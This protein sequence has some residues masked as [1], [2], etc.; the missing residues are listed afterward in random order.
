MTKLIALLL[1]L[2]VFSCQVDIP[3]EEVPVEP[4]PLVEPTPTELTWITF[5]EVSQPY[6]DQRGEPEE[7]TKYNSDNYCTVDWWWWSQGFEVT[8]IWTTYDDT[9]GWRV[10]STYEFEPIIF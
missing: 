10:D 8:F 6:F 9:Y 2:I 1:I 3:P 4:I 5:E 7:I